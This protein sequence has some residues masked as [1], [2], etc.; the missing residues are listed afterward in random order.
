MISPTPAEIRNWRFWLALF[1]GCLS[2][3]D[4]RAEEWADHLTLTAR[5]AQRPGACAQAALPIPRDMD[6][7]TTQALVSGQATLGGVR[8]QGQPVAWY[9]G[10][11]E[12]RRLILRWMGEPLPAKI[13]GR[14]R[15]EPGEK[16]DAGW[17]WAYELVES[18]TGDPPW[19]AG[20]R[21]IP[22]E[23]TSYEIYQLNLTHKEKSF[24]LRMGLRH[25]GRIYGWQYIRA[26]FVQRG[27]VFDLLRVGGP[28]YNEESTVQADVFLVLF[29]N[30]VVEAYTHF[31][32]NQREGEGIEA[33]GIP[34]I[35]FES[36]EI[37]S[38]D[39][40]LDGL[41]GRFDLGGMS[42][43]LG[44]SVGYA[45]PEKPGSI[46][47][48]DGLVVLQ[49]WMD[50]EVYG[51]LLA[52]AEGVPEHRIIRGKGEG[53]KLENQLRAQA[54]KYWV[55]KAGDRA[56]PRGLAR[57]VRFTLALGNAEPQV[58]RYQAPGWWHAMAGALPTQGYLPT[59]WWAVRRAVELGSDF[60]DPH[61]R[62]VPFELGRSSHDNDGTLGAALL[63]FGN[64]IGSPTLTTD[65]SLPAYWWADIAIDHVD[66][67]VH[68]I[69]KYSWQWIVQPYLRWMGLVHVYW[70]TGDPYLLET[71]KY[72]ADSFYRFFFTNRPHR[73]VGRDCLPCAE[74]L[75]L[76]ETTGEEMYLLRMREIL[77]EA[78][79]SYGQTEWYWPGHQ[80][81]AGPNGVA[82]I[83][84]ND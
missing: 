4:S 14:I 19:M 83:P 70:E 12:V 53:G 76:Y 27:P 84:S 73:F 57:T 63:M 16:T 64:L 24:G 62:T 60:S 44:E 39:E 72:A 81:G 54:D 59:D 21:N 17:S 23:K 47:T 41:N 6:A 10:T 80:S 49:P 45:T 67:T 42:L 9:E 26:D 30:G 48:E 13:S 11:T 5:I 68:E 58:V 38:M 46:R 77:A 31:I 3:P 71:A 52:H 51:E 35:V 65:A 20:M 36:P 37:K 34:V 43:D 33:H 61:P 25:N 18:S 66:F 28:I 2:C 55:T 8:V 79:R 82:R 7:A 40:T 74:M 75:A 29:A 78:R 15:M 50:Q 22:L 32:N 69:P 1:V 56:I